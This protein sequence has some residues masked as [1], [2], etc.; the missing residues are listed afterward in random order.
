MNRWKVIVSSQSASLL[1]PVTQTQATQQ[2]ASSFSR[3]VS[4]G[5]NQGGKGD[6]GKNSC[7]AAGAVVAASAAALAFKLYQEKDK[8]G[9]FAKK[10]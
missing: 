2:Q 4:T 3:K 10:L 7:G 9:H 5:P 6:G 8:Y 1:S